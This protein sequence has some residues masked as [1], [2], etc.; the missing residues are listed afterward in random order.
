METARFGF[1]GSLIRHEDKHAG[2]DSHLGSRYANFEENIYPN[3]YL[4]AL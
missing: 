3:G 4:E 1:K 2:F